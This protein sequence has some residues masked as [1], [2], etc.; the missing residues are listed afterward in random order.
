MAKNMTSECAELRVSPQTPMLQRGFTLLEL[1]ITVAIIGILAAVAL[2]AYNEY[3]RRAQIQEAFAFLS[4]YRTKMEQYYQ[5]NR[6]Y[7]TAA[8][9]APP[10]TGGTLT[11]PLPAVSPPS[12]FFTFTCDLSTDHQA[13]T[14]Y[15]K[16]TGGLAVG[17]EYNIDQLGG[18]L[19]TKFKNVDVT[20]AAQCW[21]SKSSAC[22]GG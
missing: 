11:A 18:R 9:C 7:G 8:G 2:P 4:D 1:M 17:H 14:L 16:G 5:D 20:P 3:I 6:N 10:V 19:T 12:K 21:L 13:F 22:N 15:A